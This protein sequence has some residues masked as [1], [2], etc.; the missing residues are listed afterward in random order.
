MSFACVSLVELASNDYLH[1][2][3]SISQETLV[4]SS[5]NYFWSL[6]NTNNYFPC[7]KNSFANTRCFHFKCEFLLSN[8]ILL[9]SKINHIRGSYP[10]KH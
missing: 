2:L 5:K 4:Q 1:N 8:S 3:L 9:P 10:A 7:F 6:S